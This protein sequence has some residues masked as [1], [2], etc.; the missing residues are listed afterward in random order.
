M[1]TIKFKSCK[2]VVVPGDFHINNIPMDCPA[3]KKL[4]AS[5]KTVGV[6]QLEKQLGQDW[7]K[8]VKPDNI[9][10][11][12]NLVSLLR[13]GPLE[14]QMTQN[15]VDVKFGKEKAVYLHPVLKP[16][17]E[18]T[19]GA[20]V[21]QEQAI[22]IAIEIA[23]FTP[24]NA[25]QL[26]K[27]IGKKIPELMFKMKKQFVEGAKQKGLVSEESAAEIFGWIEKSQRYQFN[28]SHARGYSEL[29]YQT[30]WLKCHFPL[31]FFTSYLNYSAYKGDPKEEIYQLVQD[32]RFFG[33]TVLPPD[34]RSKN[35][36]FI[37]DKKTKQIRFGL[38]HIKGVGKTAVEKILNNYISSLNTWKDFLMAVPALHKDVGI[39]LIKAG[40]CDCYSLTRNNMISQLEVIFGTTTRDEYGK[41]KEIRG[42]TPRERDYL[43]SKL[44][45][46]T[47]IQQILSNMIN[48]Q[49]PN[50]NQT[51]KP[52]L[53]KIVDE[54]F[55]GEIDTTKMKK[56]DLIDIIKEEGIFGD[57]T[58]PKIT[59]ARRT[60]LGEKL[61]TLEQ[62][63]IDT[64]TAKAMA[65]KHLLGIA[66]S[67]SAADDTNES[68]TTHTCLEL[69]KSS[70]IQEVILGSVIES[71]KHIKTTR[72]NNPGQPMCFL[73]L[74]DATYAINTAVVFPDV[75][76]KLK[77]VCKEDFVCMFGGYK[78]NGS[79]VI[80]NIR[81]LI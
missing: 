25:D 27:A 16:I 42:L 50:L 26:R 62:E 59:D 47:N 13:P 35:I 7:A 48:H 39:A 76:K 43:L 54:Y 56:Q 36:D 67:C 75:Y 14:S 73:T 31:E 34:I 68:G 71:V 30:S 41:K 66:L 28:K 55:N 81:K 29:S 33:I 12:A 24:E 60:I 69:A 44:D 32:A 57:D 77:G 70:D 22:R 40:A 10:E 5:G 49:P 6:F 51:K 65:E 3:V 72:G 21:Y 53:L 18:P 78:R 9:G 64:N 8:K 11:L 37:M 19:Y 52:E 38:G 74:S 2:C 58:I 20:L 46:K 17:L 45:D 4:L 23:N 63:I 80:Q 15:Y 79:F 61:A 1:K